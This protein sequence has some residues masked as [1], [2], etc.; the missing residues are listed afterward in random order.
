MYA[1]ENFFG[2]IQASLIKLAVQLVINLT[3]IHAKHG[4]HGLLHAV[5]GGRFLR[6]KIDAAVFVINLFHGRIIG[7]DNQLLGHATDY[8]LDHTALRF[9]QPC[10][11][12]RLIQHPH[13]FGLA[14]AKRGQQG[15]IIFRDLLI[16]RQ[17]E[18]LPLG[19]HRPLYFDILYQRVE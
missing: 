18:S 16:M 5:N 10:L 12:Q 15:Q 13:H 17:D 2:G 14:L 1:R 4:F 7:F 9:G 19:Q 6:V 8:F 11:R 3:Q